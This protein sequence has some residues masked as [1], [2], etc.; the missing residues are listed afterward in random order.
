[1]TGKKI[2][3]YWRP[4]DRM[5]EEDPSLPEV[6]PPGSDNPLGTH[7]LYLGWPAYAI[8]GTNRPYGIGRRVSSGC[9]RLYPEDIVTLFDKIEED[10]LDTVINQ[11]IKVAWI[12][13]ELYLEAHPSLTQAD[14]VE[15]E[16]GFP[17]FEFTKQDM[18]LI[19]DTAGN[20]KDILNWHAIRTVIR[21]RR[22]IPLLIGTK[23][24]ITPAAQE[25]GKEQD[26][27]E[28]TG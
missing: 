27:K 20:Y 19:L 2:G 21:E 6:I 18:R 22:G 10:K 17:D 5:R 12:D 13:N 4:T 15:Q 8:H 23:P 26:G 24:N 11:P 28:E 7:A 3:P 16:G 25:D 14:K 9:I 1:M